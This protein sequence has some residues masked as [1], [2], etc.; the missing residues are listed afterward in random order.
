MASGT[1]LHH[2]FHPASGSSSRTVTV[3]DTGNKVYRFAKACPEIGLV[4]T[5]TFVTTTSVLYLLVSYLSGL[6]GDRVPG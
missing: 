6:R 5:K 1:L 3:M 2:L 4:A